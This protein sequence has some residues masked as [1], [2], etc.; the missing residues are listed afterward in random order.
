MKTTFLIL[1][2]ACL[3]GTSALAMDAASPKADPAPAPD[4]AAAAP[5][6][7]TID[8]EHMSKADRKKYMKTTVLPEM[9]K[10]FIA[11]DAKAYKKMNCTTCHG[12]G[13]SDGKFK[14]PNPKLPKLPQPTSR[15]DF[16]ELQKKKP[17]IV[18]FMSTVVKPKVAELLGLP[19]WAPATPT[20]FG[21]YHCHT[22]V[23]DKK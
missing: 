10:L 16:L 22:K 5:P 2:L 8:W 18:K 1:S 6:A 4:A 17:E 23:G 11:F 3:L 19:Q 9:K 15:D 7:R 13:A 14:M 20:G 12:D 21:C